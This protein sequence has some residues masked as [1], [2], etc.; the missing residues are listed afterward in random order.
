MKTSSQ[1]GDLLDLGLASLWPLLKGDFLDLRPDFTYGTLNYTSDL[2]VWSWDWTWDLALTRLDLNFGTSDLGLETSLKTWMWNLRYGTYLPSLELDLEVEFRHRT[3]L[4]ETRLGTW[5]NWF[6]TWTYLCL[7]T[8][9]ST[10][11][12][13]QSVDL[14]VRNLNMNLRLAT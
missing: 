5:L 11:E 14:P 6:D 1:T 9:V 12:F 2:S 4:P 3:Y 10:L 8:W 7:G 13:K